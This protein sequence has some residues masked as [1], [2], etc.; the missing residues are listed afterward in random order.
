MQWV[1]SAW[2]SGL[3]YRKSRAACG[4]Q[5]TNSEAIQAFSNYKQIS[6]NLL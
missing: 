6:Y 2:K 4:G 1:K 5:C 3:R